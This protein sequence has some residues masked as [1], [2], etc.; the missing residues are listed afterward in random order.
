MAPS[1]NA[2]VVHRGGCHCGAVRFEAKGSAVVNVYECNCSVCTMKQ[3][4]HFMVSD[5]DFTLLQGEDKLTL[6]QFGTKQAKHLFCSIC[7]VH[8]FYKPRSHPDCYAVTVHCV[9]E[10]SIADTIVERCDGRNWEQWNAKRKA[11]HPN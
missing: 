5:A 2:T 8:S 1:E 10:G 6:Y 9:D 7:G 11:A 4:D 3:N